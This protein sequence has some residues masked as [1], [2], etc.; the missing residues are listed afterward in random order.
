LFDNTP[1]SRLIGSIPSHIL[2]Q[3]YLKYRQSN[4]IN[5]MKINFEWICIY[6]LMGNGLK[7]IFLEKGGRVIV[8]SCSFEFRYGPQVSGQNEDQ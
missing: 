3:I 7:A 8:P 6:F 2:F 4:L 5:K 1:S